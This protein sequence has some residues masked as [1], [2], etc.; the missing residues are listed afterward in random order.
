MRINE[1]L[2]KYHKIEIELLLAHVLRKPR[3]FVFMNAGVSLPA[4]QLI[5]LSALARRRQKGEPLAYILG[6]KDFYGMRF[7]VNRYVLIPRPETEI[8][9]DRVINVVQARGLPSSNKKQ[10]KA[11]HYKPPVRILDIGTGSGCIAV[12]LAKQFQIS[13]IKF[14]ITASD[15]SQDAL[16]V[17]KQNARILLGKK[18]NSINYATF[19]KIKFVQSDLLT[20]IQNRFD[21]IVANLPYGWNEWKNNTSAD[22]AGLKFEPSQALYTADHGL[23]QI[24]RLLMQISA[25][26][27]KPKLVYLEFDPRQKKELSFAIK[28]ILPSAELNFFKD[29]A[30]L[31]R[32][33]EIKFAS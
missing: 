12:S 18:S 27:I 19:S 20:N 7:K 11:L 17:A 16:N 4:I 8:I 13:N 30:G 6:Y 14:Q 23:Y 28:K 29:Y 5:R 3:E 32:Y 25:R 9:V 2:K 15:N 22:S 24:K 1:A 26:Q 31:W 10:G 33:A 21:I